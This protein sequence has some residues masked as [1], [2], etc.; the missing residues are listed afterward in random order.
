MGKKL[1]TFQGSVEEFIVWFSAIKENLNQNI[2][3]EIKNVE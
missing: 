2:K 3:V 1:L